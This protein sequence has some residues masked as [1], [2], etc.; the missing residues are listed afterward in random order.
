MSGEPKMLVSV[1]GDAK[2]YETGKVNLP[3]FTNTVKQRY[4]VTLSNGGSGDYLFT[5]GTLAEWINIT[6]KEGKQ[7]V[8][9]GTVSDA[10]YFYVSVDW[11][12]VRS[13]KT[14]TVVIKGNGE[15]VKLIVN[16][17]YTEYKSKGIRTHFESNDAVVIDGN[18]YIDNVASADGTKWEC[19]DGYGR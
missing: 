18:E 19:I 5:V 6:D 11:R 9:G 16:T 1:S 14:G 15:T 2:A 12:R 4:A 7:I 3:T 13:D 8:N 10:A 17:S